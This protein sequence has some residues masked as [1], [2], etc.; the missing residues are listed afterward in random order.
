MNER[1]VKENN[2]FNKK[3]VNIYIEL[4]IKPKEDHLAHHL[5]TII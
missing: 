1:D 4:I 5:L 2:G 3:I